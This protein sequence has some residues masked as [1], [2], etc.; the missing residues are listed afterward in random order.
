[1]LLLHTD[2]RHQRVHILLINDF[3]RSLASDFK[4]NSKEADERHALRQLWWCWLDLCPDRTTLHHSAPHWI[5]THR[6]GPD[7]IE[8]GLG[9]GMGRNGKH[10]PLVGPKTL[11]KNVQII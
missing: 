6:T 7:L 9:M 2:Q 4:E 1:L 5:T 3:G 10:F 11:K 8:M